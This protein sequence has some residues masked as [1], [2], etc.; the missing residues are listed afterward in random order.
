MLY[1]SIEIANFKVTLTSRRRYVTAQI[2][3]GFMR[4]FVSHFVIFASL[5]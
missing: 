1:T 3:L 5:T 2:D 4:M